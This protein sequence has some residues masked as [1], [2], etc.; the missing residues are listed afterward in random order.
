MWEKNR[1]RKGKGKKK[2]NKFLFTW[3]NK[4]Q[5]KRLL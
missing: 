3:D 4:G 2:E 5:N 1:R